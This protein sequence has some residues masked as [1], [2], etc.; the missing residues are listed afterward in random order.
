MQA[1]RSQHL[2]DNRLFPIDQAGIQE[3]HYS[4]VHL[5]TRYFRESRFYNG[6]KVFTKNKE[7]TQKGVR[8]RSVTSENTDASSIER[9]TNDLENKIVQQSTDGDDSEKRGPPTKGKIIQMSIYFLKCIYFKSS[10]IYR[11]Q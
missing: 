9:L 11:M 10:I 8:K 1:D 6:I 2:K 7:L 3:R 5:Q 4:S